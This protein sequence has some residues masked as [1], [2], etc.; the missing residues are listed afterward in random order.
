VELTFDTDPAG[1]ELS[2]NGRTKDAPFTRTLVVGS[3]NQIGVPSPQ[4]LNGLNYNFSSWSDGGAAVHFITAGQSPIIYTATIDQLVGDYNHNG[5]VDSAD[6]TVWR[7]TLG[8][9]VSPFNGADGSGDGIVNHADYDVWKSHFGQS[10]PPPEA[11][12][13]ASV[14]AALAPSTAAAPSVN[15]GPEEAD[16]ALQLTNYARDKVHQFNSSPVADLTIANSSVKARHTDFALAVSSVP[17][18]G[19]KDFLA[20]SGLWRRLPPAPLASAVQDLAIQRSSYLFD[21]KDSISYFQR[22]SGLL[23]QLEEFGRGKIGEKATCELEVLDMLF[24]QF[25]TNPFEGG[26]AV[27]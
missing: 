27:G 24:A 18:N 17:N 19:T 15:V 9:L 13:A 8:Q 25:G 2:L 3:V 20:S 12:G 10:Q 22:R 5:I 26:G 6:Y 16:L 1:L 21:R 11:A 4:T 23:A 14:V 7:D